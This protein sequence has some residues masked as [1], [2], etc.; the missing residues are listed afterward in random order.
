VGTVADYLVSYGS[1]VT[2]FAAAGFDANELG[3][4]L[5]LAIPIAWY[6][7]ITRTR[8]VMVWLNRA[9]LP[10]AVIAVLLTG[11]RGAALSAGIAVV[12]VPLTLDQL[13]RWKR[14][15]LGAVLLISAYA[16]QM[17]I[18]MT[19]W[20]RLASISTEL[21]QGTLTNRTLI[22]D[23][24]WNVFLKHPVLGV[25][26]GAFPVAVD[27]FGMVAHNTFLSLLTENG[28]VGFLLF[29]LFLI[30]AV[31]HLTMLPRLERRTWG[32]VLLTWAVGVSALTWE[33]RKPTWLVMVVLALHVNSARQTGARTESMAGQPL[34]GVSD[35]GS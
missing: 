6:L 3:L 21:T 17:I 22:W 23:A 9:Y 13:N 24:G 15:M 26:S 31:R 2:R 33:H 35:G 27:T 34:L 19:S 10:M 32:I 11:S 25:G 12:I 1:G 4:T 16:V 14:I 20:E 7:S 28:I 18:P 5:A 29:S 8:P 30:Q